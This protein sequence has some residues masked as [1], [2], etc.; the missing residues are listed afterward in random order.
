MRQ[1][2]VYTGQCRRIAQIHL[3]SPPPLPLLLC[4]RR[5]TT[6]LLVISE[7]ILLC[8]PNS[9]ASLQMTHSTQQQPAVSLAHPLLALP[10]ISSTCALS[11][12]LT[13]VLWF[14]FSGIFG[15]RVKPFFSHSLCNYRHSSKPLFFNNMDIS[16]GVPSMSNTSTFGHNVNKGFR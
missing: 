9:V 6:S 1:L 13:S 12:S 15:H 8:T 14:S 11:A 10:C 4:C 7:L 5:P 3:T 16:K 2:W